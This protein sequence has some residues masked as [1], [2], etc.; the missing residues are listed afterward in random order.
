[1]WST[2]GSFFDKVVLVTFMVA[3]VTLQTRKLW[4]VCVA[5]DR[6][7]PMPCPNVK[8]LTLNEKKRMQKETRQNEKETQVKKRENFEKHMKKQEKQ[9]KI[10]SPK[11][12]SKQVK[13]SKKKSKYKEKSKIV[14]NQNVNCEF[15]AL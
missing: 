1:M 11:N 14:K 13:K 12:Q 3:R 15:S 9:E 2:N 6:D 10:S 8:N 5:T 7:A 4:L